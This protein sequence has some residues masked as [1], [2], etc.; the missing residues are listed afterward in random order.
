MVKKVDVGIKKIL[1][2]SVVMLA[3]V[4]PFLE[5]SY[6]FEKVVSFPQK[7]F[8]QNSHIVLKVLHDVKQFLGTHD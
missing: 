7:F 2:L 6:F 5:P 3:V 4:A 1:C 8:F